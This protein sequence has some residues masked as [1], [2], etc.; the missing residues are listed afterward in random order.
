MELL[1]IANIL[2]RDLPDHC[3]VDLSM[4]NGAACV[5]YTDAAGNLYDIECV[6]Q[7]LEEQLLEALGKCR[8]DD[9]AS[10]FNGL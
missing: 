4:E 6:D 3:T 7:T 8:E 9:F 10:G 1:E 2:C 5:T